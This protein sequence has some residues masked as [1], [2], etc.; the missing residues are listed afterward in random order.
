MVVVDTEFLFGLRKDDPHHPE[1]KAILDKDSKHLLIPGFA[2]LEI[3]L[4][5]MSQKKDTTS[6]KGFLESLL[7]IKSQ[8]HMEERKIGLQEFIKGLEILETYPDRSFFDA[9]MA[10]IALLTDQDILSNDSAFEKIP[11]LR[12]HKLKDFMQLF[13]SNSSP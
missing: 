9:M 11:Q 7:E 13:D 12:R 1:C 3:V 6:I 2:I 8:Y 10:S 5:M 4:V